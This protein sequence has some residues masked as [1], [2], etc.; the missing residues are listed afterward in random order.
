VAPAAVTSA[1]FASMSGTIRT[2]DSV[3]DV[4]GHDLAL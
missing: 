3:R 2:S 4:L 1:S